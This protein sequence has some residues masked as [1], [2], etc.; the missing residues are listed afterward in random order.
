LVIT[1]GTAL[2]LAALL[3]RGPGEL[4]ERW[5]IQPH[6]WALVWASWLLPCGGPTADAPIS[7]AT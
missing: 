2:L 5:P 1:W 7:A 6:G 4:A 3:V